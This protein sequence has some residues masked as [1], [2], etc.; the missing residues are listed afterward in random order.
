MSLWGRRSG[1]A[2][3]RRAEG[4]SLAARALGVRAARLST[5]PNGTRVRLYGVARAAE[6]LLLSPVMERPCIAYRL[7]VEEPGWRQVLESAE[8]T[9]FLLQDEGIVVSVRGPFEV[10]LQRPYE[11]EFGYDVLRRISHLL[12]RVRGREDAPA[13]PSLPRPGLQP[14]RDRGTDDE[15]RDDFPYGRD[16][17]YYEALIQPGDRVSIEGFASV[18]V[19]PAGERAAL[20]EPPLLYTV[21]GTRESPAVVSVPEP[22][23]VAP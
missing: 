20:R 17:R 11:W 4:A 14:P 8:G 22:G 9:P 3:A 13:G 6:R 16:C 19:D 1:G 5:I 15:R 23:S 21:G 10:V 12:N 7:V 2:S 18:T